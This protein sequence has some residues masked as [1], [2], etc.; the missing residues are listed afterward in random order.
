M[1]EMK[2]EDMN[3]PVPQ[4]ETDESSK[5]EAPSESKAEKTSVKKKDIKVPKNMYNSFGNYYYR[6]AESI[7]EA[8]KPYLEEYD[9]TVILSDEIVFVEGWHYVKA[10]ARF[11]D[12][13]TGDIIELSALARE[14]ESKKGM[15][16]SQVTGATSSYAR[17]YCLNGMFLLDDTKDADSDEFVKQTQQDKPNGSNAEWKEKNA[18][19]QKP[20]IEW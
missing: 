13:E 18:Q 6:N 12:N 11:I 15:D 8:L 3:L 19:K 14:S 7:S 1:S 10:T 17:K 4:E 20:P 9:C 16:S 5:K 2:D